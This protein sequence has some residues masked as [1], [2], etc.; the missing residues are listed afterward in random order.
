MFIISYSA[1]FYALCFTSLI[2][3]WDLGLAETVVLLLSAFTYSR[4]RLMRCRVTM[5]GVGSSYFLGMSFLVLGDLRR[6]MVGLV[7][8]SEESISCEGL[9]FI[10]QIIYN[11]K[12]HIER[13]ELPTVLAV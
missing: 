2:D 7:V 10:T 1:S 8:R 9:R 5:R 4:L 12:V 6:L 11:S 13:T 3:L